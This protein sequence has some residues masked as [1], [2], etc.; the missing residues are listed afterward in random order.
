MEQMTKSNRL[1]ERV[2]RRLALAVWGRALFVSFVISASLYLAL[3]LFS[4]LTGYWTGWFPLESISSVAIGTLVLSAILFR[5]P[6]REQAARLID[7]RQGT[8]DLFLT[9][10]MLEQAVGNYKP[11]VAQDAEKQAQKIKPAQVVEFAWAK[12][13]GWVCASTLVLFL[14]LQY[15]PQLDPF[16][17]VQAAE[18]EQEKVKEFQKEKKA[19][20]ARMAE[21]KNKDNGAGDEESKDVKLAVENLKSD[22]RKMTPGKKQE[23]AKT[24]AG[25]QKSLGGK[26]RQRAEENMKSMMMKADQAQKF[27][28]MSKDDGMKKWSKELQEGSTQSL[29]KEMDELKD[30]LQRLMKEKDP[31]KREKLQNEIQKKLKEMESFAREQTSSKPMAAALKRAMKQMQMAQSKGLSPEEAFKE[32]MESMDLAKMELKEVAQSAK[33]MKKL[34]EALKVLQ[35]AKKAND[36]SGLDGEACENCMTLE[37]Y[38]ELYAEM[39]GGDMPGEGTGNEGQGGGGKVDEDDTGDKGF[40]TEKSKSAITAGKVLLSFKS[41]GLSDSGEARK[42]YNKLV[43]DLKQGMSEAIMQEQIPPGYHDGI[44]KYFN[45]LEKKT[46]ENTPQK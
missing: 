24:L 45:S 22:F 9:V 34:E 18:I 23:N 6:D 35:M 30:Q 41:K 7:Q 40:K 1:I 17:E 16:G 21:L 39:M 5:R 36:K 37:D 32:A 3:M 20:K 14:T 10:T 12:R 4:R 31:V 28:G 2:Q 27:G 46:D 25:H 33:D 42:N 38:E 44:K 8:K 29:T 19:T 11:L 13:V 15:A 43:T 26:W